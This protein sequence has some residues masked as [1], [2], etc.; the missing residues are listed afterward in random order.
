MMLRVFRTCLQSSWEISTTGKLLQQYLLLHSYVL[1]DVLNAGQF[2]LG[3]PRFEPCSE[4]SNSDMLSI[5][6]ISPFKKMDKQRIK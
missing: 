6:F 4:A 2:V 3:D 5:V 1:R